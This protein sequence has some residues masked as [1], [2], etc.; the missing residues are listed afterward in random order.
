MK[1]NDYQTFLD[2]KRMR[3]A[4]CGIEIQD[5]DINPVA[6]PFQGESAEG[7]ASL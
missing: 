4:S 5:S 6:F 3:I 7:V 1:M 2:T